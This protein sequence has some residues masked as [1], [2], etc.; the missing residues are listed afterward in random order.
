MLLVHK[1]SC[2]LLIHRL[3][4]AMHY[5][6]VSLVKGLFPNLIWKQLPTLE[7]KSKEFHAQLAPFPTSVSTHRWCR[8]RWSDKCN[9]NNYAWFAMFPLLIG[10]VDH[11]IVSNI[12]NCFRMSLGKGPPNFQLVIGVKWTKYWLI[13]CI[14][15]WSKCFH[16]VF[17]Q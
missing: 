11:K 3:Y 15:L 17:V 4:N 8:R 7:P 6:T 5:W 12:G 9:F 1:A 13:T 16:D 2:L 10:E 14:N